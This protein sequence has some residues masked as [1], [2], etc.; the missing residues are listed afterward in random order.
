METQPEASPQLLAFEVKQNEVVQEL[1]AAIARGR[2][3]LKVMVEKV[4]GNNSDGTSNATTP[5][6][7]LALYKQQSTML[8]QWEK[9]FDSSWQGLERG[10]AVQK[11]EFLCSRTEG[12][13]SLVHN[14]KAKKEK[15][16]KGV[17][18]TAER[19]VD[20]EMMGG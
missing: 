6:P 11:T 19:G 2:E 16:E 15:I 9:M 3:E 18:A 7:L 10:N 12:L 17:E 13:K 20:A 5:S 1:H 8:D 4:E 14:F